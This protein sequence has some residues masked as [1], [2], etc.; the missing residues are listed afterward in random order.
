M[1]IKIA[2]HEEVFRLGE[3][4]PIHEFDSESIVSLLD[5]KLVG[6]ALD[7]G[8]VRFSNEKYYIIYGSIFS[9]RIWKI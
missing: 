9:F 5:K 7:I 3:H 8:N 4:S 2:T 1:N 6:Y